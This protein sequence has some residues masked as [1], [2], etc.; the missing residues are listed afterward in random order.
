[1]HFIHLPRHFYKVSYKQEGEAG[2]GIPCVSAYER[3]FT[4]KEEA[5][6]FANNMTKSAV[7]GAVELEECVFTKWDVQATTYLR[8]HG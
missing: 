8:R 3:F 4:D 6:I 1:M 5:Y 7:Q 2:Y